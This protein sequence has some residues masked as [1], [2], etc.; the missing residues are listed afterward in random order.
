MRVM[1]T[2]NAKSNHTITVNGINLE[3][4]NDYD[5]YSSLLEIKYC[6]IYSI[7]FRNGRIHSFSGIQ[8]ITIIQSTS[9]SGMTCYGL[10]TLSF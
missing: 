10:Q 7:I 3:K 8:M 6:D 9:F 4:I 1:Q 5:F 2:G